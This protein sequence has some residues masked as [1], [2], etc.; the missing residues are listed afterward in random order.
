MRYKKIFMIFMSGCILVLS[1]FLLS[2]ASAQDTQP[3][4]GLSESE[5]VFSGLV[6]ETLQRSVTVSVT[7]GSI[8]DL[9]LI[10]PDL[11][12]PSTKAVILSDR[13]SVS[14]GDISTLTGYQVLTIT[15]TGLDRHGNYEGNLLFMYPGM[16]EEQE[17]GIHLVVELQAVP[18]VDTD[19]NSKSLTL[20]V[21]PSAV[22][23]PFGR[24]EA[25]TSSPV[26]GEVALSLI[27][28][29]D[30]PA[31][32]TNARVLAMQNSLGRT[33]PENAIRVTTEFPIELGAKDA[34]T[35]HLEA[36]GRNLPAGEYNGTLLVN[37][38]N[39]V[40]PV[41]IPIR[42]QVKD[43]PILAFILLAA[44]PIVGILFFY[45]NKDGKSLL[46]ARQRIK[47][48]QRTL[49]T[50]RFLTIQDQEQIRIKLESVM[51]LLLNKAETA[52]VDAKL[53]EIDEFIKAQQMMGEQ[54]YLTLQNLK[55]RVDSIQV[56][57]ILRED[58][59]QKISLVQKKLEAGEGSSWE[60]VQSQTD[61]IQ[62]DIIEMEGL[63]Q[64]YQLYSADK[65]EMMLPRLDGARSIEEFRGIM[66]EARDII[67]RSIKDLFKID[68][69]SEKP[70]WRKFDL[71]LQWR[72]ITVS[73]VVYLFTLFVGWITLYGS[74]P[75]FGSNREDYITLFLWGV[76][77]N[78]VGGQAVDLKSVFSRQSDS[79]PLA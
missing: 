45:W 59:L 4:L 25:V 44:G 66:T 75:T 13:I 12:D 70:E 22:D 55:E 47:N 67:P 41:Q 32:I 36:R 73:A 61:A 15:I 29:G 24:A 18:A 64:E 28:A 48:L 16:P 26:L 53:I 58:L 21:E 74:S 20:F 19:V 40:V 5:L 38:E 6:G 52:E 10:I 27:Q 11:I 37:V 33:L 2:G 17:I 49:R 57:K 7:E 65:Q 42:V 78:V 77:S 39:Q 79:E 8:F 76:A 1:L 50:G 72:R 46:E 35:L 68:Q 71:V 43:G 62:T 56:G 31:T 69:T 14:P 9:Q 54:A 30:S 63:V 51:D 23:V 60:V 3:V 34:A